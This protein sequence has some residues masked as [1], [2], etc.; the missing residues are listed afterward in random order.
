MLYARFK[1][2]KLENFTKTPTMSMPIFCKLFIYLSSRN[3]FQSFDFTQLDNQKF[4][5]I[6]LAFTKD[7][8]ELINL[9]YLNATSDELSII[10]KGILKTSKYHLTEVLYFSHELILGYISFRFED[11]TVSFSSHKDNDTKIFKLST[12]YPQIFI[13]HLKVEYCLTFSVLPKVISS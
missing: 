5:N 7:K 1:D 9:V 11:L 8:R 13:F 10:L 2:V 12:I 6:C 3:L 4:D